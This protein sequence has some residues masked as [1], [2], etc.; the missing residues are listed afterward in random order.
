MGFLTH[1]LA[2]PESHDPNSTTGQNTG[3]ITRMARW[4]IEVFES[5]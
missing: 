4:D 1:C 5:A 3:I 2:A